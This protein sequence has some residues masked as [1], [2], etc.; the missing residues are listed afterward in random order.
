MSKKNL[1][2]FVIISDTHFGCQLALC[3]PSGCQ[4][5]NGGIYYP[6][7]IQKGIWKHWEEFNGEQKYPGASTDYL[8]PQTTA[9]NDKG[10]QVGSL[11]DYFGLPTGVKNIKAKYSAF[12]K[13]NIDD[14]SL[15]LTYDEKTTRKE[16]ISNN[17][18]K[19]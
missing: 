10:F 14:V 19:N 11:E 2:T 4:F 15:E 5:D 13:V 3:P 17:I 8:V 12:E 9:P 16:T 7:D 1:K 6:N 18:E